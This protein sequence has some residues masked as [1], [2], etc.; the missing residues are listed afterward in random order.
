MTRPSIVQRH[1]FAKVFEKSGFVSMSDRSL[2][3]TGLPFDGLFVADKWNKAL[4]IKAGLKFP[5]A[6]EGQF[7]EE[8]KLGLVALHF[9]HDDTPYLIVAINLPRDEFRKIMKPWLK[10]KYSLLNV[11]MPMAQAA[12]ICASSKQPWSRLQG[13]LAQIEAEAVLKSIGRCGL[14]AL[15]GAR[16]TATDTISYFQNLSSN[17]QALWADMKKSFESLKEF[18]LNFHSEMEQ[19]FAALGNLSTE[20]KTQ[21]AC[22]MTGEALLRT[23]AGG[24]ISSLPRLLPTITLK[25]KRVSQ[26]LAEIISLE[27]KGF[28]LPDKSFLTREALSCAL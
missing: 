14:E 23:L 11:L 7:F 26:M 21:I 8:P 6:I 25:M 4:L 2:N 12:E 20:Q 24:G 9:Q 22:S 16:Q 18:T 28:I 19:I 1:Q 17:P 27:K 15:R 10:E 3:P 13:T 5:A